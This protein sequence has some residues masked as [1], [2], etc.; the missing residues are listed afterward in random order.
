MNLCGIIKLKIQFKIQF[1]STS[2][3]SDWKS[4]RAVT[5]KIIKKNRYTR[6][7]VLK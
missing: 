6:M 1:K 2:D 5:A 3:S 7:Y 4:I